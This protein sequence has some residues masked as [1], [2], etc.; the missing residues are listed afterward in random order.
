MSRVPRSLRVGIVALTALIL[1]AFPAFVG[2]VTATTLST[3]TSPDVFITELQTTNTTASEEFVEIYNNT[4]HDIDLADLANGGKDLWKLQFF[5]S[6][7]TANGAPDWTKPSATLSL[8]GTIS[9]HD[10]F[11]LSSAQVQNGVNVVYKPGSIDPDQTYTARLSDTGGGL[12]LVDVLGAATT[13]HDR[14]MWKQAT[15]SQVL[16]ANV[17]PTPTVGA[18]LQRLPN[19]DVEYVQ[20]DGSLATF[21]VESQIS[22]KDAWI[23]PDSAPSSDPSSATDPSQQIDSAATSPASQ[24]DTP[25]QPDD[26]ATPQTTNTAELSDPSITEALPNPAFPQTD[27]ENEYIEV[28][29][30]N[31][32]S[33][34]LKG[35]T[36]E[37]GTTTLH[38]FTFTDNVLLAPQSYTAFYSVLTKIALANGGGQV[39]LLSPDKEVI[40]ESSPYL[41]APEGQAWAWD[42]STWQWTLTPTPG[43]AN[44]ITHP[45]A[46]A[47]LNTSNTSA[48]TIKP[49]KATVKKSAAKVKGVSTVRTSKA[50][51]T[52]SKTSTPPQ[53]GSAQD[54]AQVT[55]IHPW[56][57]A[58][59][60][61]AAILYGVYEYRADIKNY[62]HQRAANR[63]ARRAAR[64]TA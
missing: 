52:A 61:G 43:A 9:A 7:S 10:Y 48:K 29:N 44:N 39:R 45:I 42:G 33:L 30:P 15:A 2:A 28:Y 6:T 47:A 14:V 19:E 35:Y 11:L 32:A 27:E 59:I 40:S 41:T 56:T 54:A 51:K 22:P 53:S 49:A 24:T 13:A 26:T 12:Q 23:A 25:A 57:L 31:T 36:L 20:D 5:S 64:Q 34:D 50:K 8:N 37:T 60:G 18:S 58:A 38:D 63:A 3:V 1:G 4:D 17:L 62:F 16:P 46:P 55:P 21:A